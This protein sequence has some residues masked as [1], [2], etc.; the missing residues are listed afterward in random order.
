MRLSLEAG[1]LVR[2]DRLVD[3]LWAPRGET[4]RRNTLQSKVAMLRRALGD[5]SVITSRDGG[6]ALAVEP[7]E[8][9]AL[10]VM[11]KAAAASR[12]LDVGDDRGAADLCAAT[13]ELYRGE[14]LQAAGDGDWVHPHRARL[15]EARLKLVEIGFSARLRLGDVGN[16]IG[17]LEAA[18]AAYPFQESLWQLLI[19]ALYRAGR[20]ADALAAYQRVGNQLADELGLDPGPQLQ[21]LERSILA[22]DASLGLPVSTLGPAESDLP[23]GN[24]PSMSADLV[25]RETEVAAL[26]DLLATERLVEIVGPGGIG[27]TAV[28]IAVGRRLAELNGSGTGGVWLARLETAI[29]ADDVVDTVIAAFKVPGGEPALYERLR[30]TAALVILDNCEHVLDAAAA[31]AV[32]LL[33]A[34]PALRILCTSQVP[35]DVDGEAVFELAP[36]ALSDAVALFT[37]RATAQRLMHTSSTDDDAVLD[38]CRSLDGL[39]L[40]IELAAARTKTLSIEEISWRLEDRLQLLSD[41]TSRRPERRRSLKSTIRWSYELLFPDDQRGL[42]ALATF[43]GGAPLSAVES[44]LEALDVPAAAAIDVVGRLVSRSLVIVDEDH[45]ASTGSLIDPGAAPRGPISTAR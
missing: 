15:E 31:L 5:P 36:L 13:L 27:K 38:L 43:A 18:V 24:L 33:D 30:G 23:T 16:V 42:W 39:P 22:Q 34:A 32:R 6:Y 11:G 1:Q 8:V 25:G 35:L 41:P 45:G 29:T 3:D 14:V 19:T 21:Q 44:V 12:L 9:D 20:Q 7:F 40:A 37:R 2:A 28:A 26:S 4:T 10:A 17:E